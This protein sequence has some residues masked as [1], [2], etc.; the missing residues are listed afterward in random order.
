MK[1][2][3]VIQVV[4]DEN[5]SK[6]QLEQ[7]FDMVSALL[8]QLLMDMSELEKKEALFMLSEAQNGSVASVKVKWRGSTEGQK[9]IGLKR[10][11]EACKVLLRSI[12]NKIF[13]KL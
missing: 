4:K 11:A 10:Y 3:E 1:L 6:E 13:S 8:A 7:Y 2:A 9:L 12:K 5:L